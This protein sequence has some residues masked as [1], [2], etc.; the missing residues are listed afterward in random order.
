[1]CVCTRVL[2]RT[3]GAFGSLGAEVTGS[4][5]L[6]NMRFGNNT[7]TDTKLGSPAGVPHALNHLPRSAA[8]Y[9]FL[10]TGEP[11]LLCSSLLGHGAL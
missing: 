11:R 1:M 8:S 5:E 3:E 9:L 10:V 4:Y 2:G 7:D 6:L